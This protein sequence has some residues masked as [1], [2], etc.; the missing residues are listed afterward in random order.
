MARRLLL[1]LLLAVTP[2]LAATKHVR[3]DGNDNTC[4]GTED[5]G[6]GALSGMR[7]RWADR[8]DQASIPV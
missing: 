2:A 7:E 1:C 4:D 3:T 5:E 8:M 6:A